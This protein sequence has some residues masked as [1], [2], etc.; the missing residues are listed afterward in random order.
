M[1]SSVRNQP[2]TQS[3]KRSYPAN[4]LEN[5]SDDGGFWKCVELRTP[6]QCD[7]RKKFRAQ[8]ASYVVSYWMV[9]HRNQV[10]RDSPDCGSNLA[11]QIICGAHLHIIYR[12]RRHSA[13]SITLTLIGGPCSAMA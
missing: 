2:F 3:R 12:V 6:S 13:G 10:E 1:S 9:G 11:R 8:T 7:S 5:R 4:Q